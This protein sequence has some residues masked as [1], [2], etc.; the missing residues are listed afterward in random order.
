MKKNNCKPKSIIYT[1]NNNGSERLYY[2]NIKEIS[3]LFLNS[4]DCFVPKYIK[5]KHYN[6]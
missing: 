2:I 3:N 1:L 4:E 5:L 6:K